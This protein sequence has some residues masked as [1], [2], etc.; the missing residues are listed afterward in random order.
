MNL[1]LSKN[2]RI[3]GDAGISNNRPVQLKGYPVIDPDP[4]IQSRYEQLRRNGESHNIAE[5]LTYRS[6][7]S[8]KTDD[9]FFRGQGTLDAQV[10]DDPHYMQQITAN[11]RAA[12]GG[13]N[14]NPNYSYQAGLAQYPGDPR[15]FVGS[16]GEA[17][18]RAEELNVN[19]DGFVTHK[20]SEPI[21]DPFAGMASKGSSRVPIAS[22]LK[23]VIADQ[24]TKRDPSLKGRI[25]PQMLDET[26]G[27]HAKG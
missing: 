6:A 19:L 5:M 17:K 20:A 8:S 9:D 11:Y 27:N 3:R 7:P 23:A 26:H 18:R 22:D 12:T 4:E 21:S 25:S 16:A 13:Q 10:G 24:M 2:S 1:P 14:P 15:A